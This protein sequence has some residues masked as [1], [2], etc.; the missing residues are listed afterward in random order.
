MKTWPAKK[1]NKIERHFFD[2]PIFRTDINTWAKE[3]ED[4]KKKLVQ[5]LAGNN[6]EITEYEIDSAEKWLRPQ[7]SAYYYSEMVGMI[8][9]FTINMQI[10]GEIWFIKEKISKNLKRKRWYLADPKIFEFW[11]IPKSYKNKEIFS[12]INNRLKEENR[13]SLLKNRY[14]DLEAFEHSG[15]YLNFIELT[16]FSKTL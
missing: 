11:I 3:Q 7:W 2:I 13:K 14:I 1:F 6:K 9:L 5:Y 15:K 16:D 10:R 4:K 8:R 12:W